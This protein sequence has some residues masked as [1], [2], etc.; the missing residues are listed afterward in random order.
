MPRRSI[1]I[2][3]VIIMGLLLSASGAAVTVLGV[4]HAA[5]FHVAFGSNT[6]KTDSTG[7]AIMA[8]GAL[9][10]V[11]GV[12]KAGKTVSVYG[13]DDRPSRVIKVTHLLIDKPWLAYLLLFVS[14]AFLINSLL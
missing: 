6:I 4:S 8:I 11:V 5:A 14:V 7:L 13:G 1:T 12:M 10:V 2:T 9:F 3:S